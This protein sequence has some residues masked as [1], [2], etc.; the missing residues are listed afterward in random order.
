[1]ARLER[2]CGGAV[3]EDDAVL[4]VRDELLRVNLPSED[5][6][7][8]DE[9]SP[10]RR[11]REIL[12][13]GY[14]PIDKRVR[15]TTDSTVGDLLKDKGRVLSATFD[16]S[17][18]DFANLASTCNAKVASVELQLLGDIGNGRPTVTLLYDGTSKLRSCQPGIEDYV[19]L[20]G[21]DRTRFAEVTSLRV[22]GRSISPVATVNEWKDGG[23]GEDGKTGNV[24]LAGLPLASQYTV[25]IDTEIGENP[26]LDW[27][28]LE[29]V[30]IRVRYDYSD[31]FA[32]GQ[33][34]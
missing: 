21:R 26:D 28:K 19:D 17:L 18:D 32:E 22:P 16:I 14:V 30:L 23:G 13:V 5:A 29:D 15:Y 24:S 9:L 7:T 20:I 1:M 31:V 3:N 33:C 8:G 4:S 27:D 10:E 11:F 2:S 6:V 12:S 34:E 25:L